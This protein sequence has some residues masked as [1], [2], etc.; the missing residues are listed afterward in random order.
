MLSIPHTPQPERPAYPVKEAKD[1]RS[2]YAEEFAATHCVE[3]KVGDEMLGGFCAPESSEL[4]RIKLYSGAP[5]IAMLER[6]RAR[7]VVL[8][9]MQDGQ[10]VHL[11]YVVRGTVHKELVASGDA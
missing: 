1:G 5:R 7:P 9:L 2:R 4:R 6:V 8:V 10:M 11:V 3:M